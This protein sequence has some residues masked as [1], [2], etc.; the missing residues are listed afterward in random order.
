MENFLNT[1]NRLKKAGPLNS[2]PLVILLH[3]NLSEPS[4]NLWDKVWTATFPPALVKCEKSVQRKVEDFQLIL[5]ESR[6]RGTLG[7]V[8][9]CPVLLCGI[10]PSLSY[11]TVRKKHQDHSA[12]G[13]VWKKVTGES[14]AC[15]AWIYSHGRYHNIYILIFEKLDLLYCPFIPDR[16]N[17]SLKTK[18]KPRKPWGA[19]EMHGGTLRELRIFA[20]QFPHEKI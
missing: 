18:K 14:R 10:N 16:T 2:K 4:N 8:K 19:C 5:P 12:M 7:D 3:S 17:N 15:W 9:R 20:E 6:Q 13:L 11:K 1:W